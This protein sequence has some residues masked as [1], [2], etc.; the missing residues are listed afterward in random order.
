MNKIDKIA[1]RKELLEQG[2]YFDFKSSIDENGEVKSEEVWVK[3]RVAF[4]IQRTSQ[5]YKSE[6][7]FQCYNPYYKVKQ[8]K[9]K[10]SVIQIDNLEKFET[11]IFKL[12]N[13]FFFEI[14]G[15]YLGRKKV[16][17]TNNEVKINILLSAA[18]QWYDKNWSPSYLSTKE[19]K[20]WEEKVFKRW[21][22]I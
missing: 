16:I 5:N 15:C 2:Y 14:G 20:K 4:Y 22:D 19:A 11:Y 6:W 13:K 17:I 3:E 1:K 21:D 8:F 12:P 18:D 7:V 9:S 10:C